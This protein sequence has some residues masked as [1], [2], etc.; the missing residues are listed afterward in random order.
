[1]VHPGLDER[2]M[3]GKKRGPKKKKAIGSV[4]RLTVT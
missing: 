3:G 4:L 1:M 2:K